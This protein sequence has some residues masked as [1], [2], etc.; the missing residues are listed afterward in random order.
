MF[1]AAL[2]A[3]AAISFIGAIIVFLL[4][5]L[6]TIH[7]LKAPLSS[8][9]LG[10][11]IVDCGES[12]RNNLFS[13][14][15]RGYQLRFTSLFILLAVF[16]STMSPV[17]T[18]IELEDNIVMRS[19]ENL[20]IHNS[21]NNKTSIDNCVDAAKKSSFSFVESKF[22]EKQNH[23]LQI[24]MWPLVATIYGFL[25]AGYFRFFRKCAEEPLREII[26]RMPHVF[27]LIHFLLA[28]IAVAAGIIQNQL[29]A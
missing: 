18:L 3:D 29:G 21:L 4:T 26:D 27:H 1:S 9:K 14:I 25:I 2:S 24:A 23:L 5:L 17:S 7:E 28:A 16:V 8:T 11:Q 22:S 19:C 13:I 6:S 20:Y 12:A 10:S 15:E